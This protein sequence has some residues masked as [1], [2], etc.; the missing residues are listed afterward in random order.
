MLKLLQ[1]VDQGLADFVSFSW[2]PNEG[3]QWQTLHH[4]VLDDDMIP[5]ITTPF[6]TALPVWNCC[7]WETL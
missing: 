3:F 4:H 5:N 6:S 7:P 1:N 2:E